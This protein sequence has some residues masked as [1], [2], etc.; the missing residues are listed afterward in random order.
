MVNGDIIKRNVEISNT[1]SNEGIEKRIKFQSW[2]IKCCPVYGNPFALF[3][4][5]WPCSFSA[6]DYILLGPTASAA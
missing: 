4:F 1:V 6:D 3:R 2:L 5:L